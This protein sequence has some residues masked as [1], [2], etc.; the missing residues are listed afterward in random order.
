MPA[1]RETVM[2]I[3]TETESDIQAMP[4][5]AFSGRA[6]PSGQEIKHILV[7]RLQHIG[8]VLLT[9]PL[10]RTLKQHYPQAFI[11]ILVYKGTETILT[12]NRDIYSVYT[13]DRSLK[14][15]G[16]RSQYRGEKVLWRNLK[17]WHYDL[18]LN[19]SD[20]WRAA[21]YCLGLRPAFS[22]GFS[23]KKR[24]HFLWRYCHSA[25]VDTSQQAVRHTVLNHLSIL[26]PLGFSRVNTTVSLFWGTEHEWLVRQLQ[27]Q[28]H[29]KHYVLIQPAARWAFKTWSPSYFV[30]VI[31]HL[32]HLGKQVVLTGGPSPDEHNIIQEILSAVTQPDRVVDLCGRT[33]LPDLALLIS[34]ADLFIGVDSVPMHMAAAL[35]IPS[36][37]LFGPTNLNQWYPWNAPHTLLWAGDYRQLPAPGDVNTGTD[38]RYPDAIPPQAVIRAADDC[39]ADMAGNTA[40]PQ[41]Q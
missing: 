12:G 6:F 18:V 3:Q 28:Y 2:K 14:H 38:E 15:N 33:E 27:Q 22:I 36:V 30:R 9:T 34:G 5:T 21:L 13:V 37:V 23:R 26:A 25:L 8:D 24:H 1:I 17:Q 40:A 32:T 4:E 35:K 29:L 19:L 11:D 41:K 20:Q 16:I 39:L 7:I 31:N 10:I